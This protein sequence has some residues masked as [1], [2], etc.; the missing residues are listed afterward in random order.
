[1]SA[2]AGGELE[3]VEPPHRRVPCVHAVLMAPLA[4]RIAS[5]SRSS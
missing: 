1:M 3:A 5:P 4:S 2:L